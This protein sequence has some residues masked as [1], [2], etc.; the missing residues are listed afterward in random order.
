MSSSPVKEI[1]QAHNLP[2]LQPEKMKH[3][4]FLKTLEQWTPDV[5]VVTAFGRILPKVILDLPSRGC[6]NVH[7]SLLPHY[8]GAAPI[9][10]AVMN[11]DSQTGITTMLM[12][13]G[14]DTGAIL[15]QEPVAIGPDDTAGEVS[16]RLAEVGG[17]LLIKTL[18][19]WESRQITP[20]AQ[21]GNK[22]T[23]APLLKKED[24]IIPWSRGAIDIANR[25][26]GLSPWPGAYTFCQKDRLTIWKGAPWF[27]ENENGSVPELPG[28][29]LEVGKK[30][31]IV[32]T[33]QGR[34]AITELQ[35]ANRKRMTVGQFL[36]GYQ[37]RS[38]ILLTTEPVMP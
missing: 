4:E 2:I 23:L 6:I 26:R 21:D 36:S 18:R 19:G 35:P 16:I 38:G 3:P 14:M 17:R 32:A 33:G 28:T 8:R 11:G 13:E 5:I 37:L 20:Y 22:A 1:A 7:A 27:A 34:L 25:I 24:G 10:W 15:L 29:I 9:Q 12:D 30:E 31:I